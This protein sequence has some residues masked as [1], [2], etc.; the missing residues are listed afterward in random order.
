MSS[1][2]WFMEKLV[3]AEEVFKEEKFVFEGEKTT[4]TKHDALGEFEFVDLALSQT[5]TV[6]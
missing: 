1:E 6:I 2:K 4:L 5:V 3:E